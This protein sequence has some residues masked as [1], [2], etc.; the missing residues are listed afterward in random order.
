MA[1]ILHNSHE[2]IQRLMLFPTYN[3]SPFV[4]MMAIR[5]REHHSTRADMKTTMHT[6]RELSLCNAEVQI[7]ITVHHTPKHCKN[8]RVILTQLETS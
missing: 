1:L 6:H 5:S 4:I 8:R 7:G 3:S 2:P